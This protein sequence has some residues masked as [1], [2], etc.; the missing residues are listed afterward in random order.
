MAKQ[1]G[2]D[3]RHR[4]T[5]GSVLR[6]YSLPNGEK[7]VSV[8]SDTFRSAVDAANNAIRRERS[9][10]GSLGGRAGERTPKRA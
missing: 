1:I 3:H 8:R 4:D 6:E 10:A 7:I 5:H 2:L 9:S